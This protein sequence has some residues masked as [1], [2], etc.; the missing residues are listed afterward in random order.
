MAYEQATI[1]GMVGISFIMAYLSL[2][3]DE[4]HVIAKFLFLIGTFGGLL[5]TA[6]LISNIMTTDA[7]NAQTQQVGDGTFNILTV[8]IGL[9][10]L[11]FGFYFIKQTWQGLWDWI[12]KK[13]KYK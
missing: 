13:E 4:E 3:M 6:S 10:F 8:L 7:V 11:Y 12:Y 2:N 9:L 1:L 5:M